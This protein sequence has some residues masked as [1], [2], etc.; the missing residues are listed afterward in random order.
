MAKFTGFQKVFGGGQKF[1]DSLEGLLRQPVVISGRMPNGIVGRRGRPVVYDAATGLFKPIVLARVE[2][3]VEDET[4]VDG[5]VP[6]V[7]LSAYDGLIAGQTYKL[8]LR[9]G[10]TADATVTQVVAPTYDPISTLQTNQDYVALNTDADLAQVAYIAPA[11]FNPSTKADGFVYE[12]S[13]SE[14]VGV[15]VV[16]EG[17]KLEHLLGVELFGFGAKVINGLVFFYTA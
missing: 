8:L 5:A 4:V 16:L 15:A 10:T 3:V 12:D 11:T 13:D 2:A 1:H 6:K 9:D 14:T 7:E 17:A